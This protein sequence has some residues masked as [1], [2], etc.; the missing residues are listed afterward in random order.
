LRFIDADGARL[1]AGNLSAYTRVR[2]VGVNAEFNSAL[3][4]V[5]FSVRFDLRDALCASIESFVENA[6]LAARAPDTRLSDRNR[7]K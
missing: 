7:S 3:C 1:K 5:C 6:G 2:R 4:A